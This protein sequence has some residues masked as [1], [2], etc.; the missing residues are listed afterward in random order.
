MFTGTMLILAHGFTVPNYFFLFAL[1][2]ELCCILISPRWR[3]ESSCGVVNTEV[4][5]MLNLAFFQQIQL[6]HY[7][8]S[9]WN[10]F[11]PAPREYP[12]HVK[13][14]PNDQHSVRVTWQGVMTD[15]DEETLQGYIV[16]TIC[17]PFIKWFQDL[18]RGCLKT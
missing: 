11:F 3:G 17:N 9:V 15:W 2:E 4:I 7:Y 14:Y 10:L 6:F 1:S 16:S 5:S 8:T 12:R 18:M 13:V